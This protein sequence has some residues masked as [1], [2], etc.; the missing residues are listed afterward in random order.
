VSFGF[1]LDMPHEYAVETIRLFGDH[2]IPKLDR[3]PVHRTTR[4]REAAGGP[5]QLKG[6][7]S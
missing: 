1:P 6:P 2:V 7:K 3:D 4:F 5:L